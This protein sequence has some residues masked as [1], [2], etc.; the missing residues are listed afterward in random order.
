MKY[1]FLFLFSILINATFFAQK[2]SYLTFQIQTTVFKNDKIIATKIQSKPCFIYKNKALSELELTD[3]IIAQML[4]FPKNKKSAKKID[5]FQKAQNFSL[6][7][8]KGKIS[9]TLKTDFSRLAYF[10]NT[11]KNKQKSKFEKDFSSKISLDFKERAIQEFSFPL[12]SFLIKEKISLHIPTCI[13]SKFSN[14]AA[15]IVS[16][17]YRASI[18]HLNKNIYS[19]SSAGKILDFGHAFI[20][21]KSLKTNKLYFLDGWPD[22]QWQEGNQHF[23]WNDSVDS[24]RTSDHHSI[25]F[26]INAKDLA[27]IVKQIENYKTAC[28]EYKTLDFNCTDATTQILEKIGLYTRKDQSN[29]VFPASFGTQLMEKLNTLQICYEFDGMKIR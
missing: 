20:G 5:A 26:N 17:Y 19:T 11:A 29:T 6:E 4:L 21:V 25:S 12:D 22:A 15:G 24:I 27:T 16:V 23:T 13:S 9:G 2:S 10:S 14:T 8:E 28:I 7:L 18:E 3:T 1:L